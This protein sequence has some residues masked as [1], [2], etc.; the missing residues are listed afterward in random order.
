[1][2]LSSGV[3]FRCYPTAAQANALSAWMGCQRFIYNA[4]VGEYR[5]FSKF[6]DKTLSCTGIDVPVDQQYAQFKDRDLTPFLYEPNGARAKAGLNK[7]ILD[8]AWGKVKLFT[9]YKAQRLNKLVLAI[10]PH[11][12]SQEC[13]RCGHTHPD[14]RLSQAMFECLDCGFTE[15]ADVNAARVVKTRGIQKLIDGEI[16]VKEK[17][18]AM[19]L[20]K[21]SSLG[22]ELPDVMRGEKH[23]RRDK[24]IA[25]VPQS[26]VNRETPA[27]IVHTI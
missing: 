3:K 7:A 22:Q 24:S 2:A 4:K 26:S 9:T 20:K 1:M 8:S 15:N 23:V 21:K 12:T 27:T 16:T 19:R 14:N 17:K 18:R 25:L 10:N 11:G 6:R 13:S 5:Y